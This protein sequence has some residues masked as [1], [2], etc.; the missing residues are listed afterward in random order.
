MTTEKQ[1]GLPAVR[2]ARNI[3]E[4]DIRQVSIYLAETSQWV[5]VES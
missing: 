4:S 3:G 2:K 5:E 1:K